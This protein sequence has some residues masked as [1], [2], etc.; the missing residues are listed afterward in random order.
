M[1]ESSEFKQTK[2]LHLTRNQDKW[3]DIGNL[4]ESFQITQSGLNSVY[5]LSWMKFVHC[6]TTKSPIW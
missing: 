2:V 4:V 3:I 5:K 6:V 1:S